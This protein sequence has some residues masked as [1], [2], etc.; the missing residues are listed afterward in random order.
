MGGSKGI[1]EPNPPAMPTVGESMQD[2][3][4]NMPDMYNL[5]KEYA[6]KYAA[7]EFENYQ[8]YMPAYTK[9][10][11]DM[12]RE[13]Y[14]EMFEQRD[15]LSAKATEYMEQGMPDWAREEARDIY[16]ANLGT[17]A[18]SPIGAD[19][20]ST[21]MMQENEKWKQYG[22]NLAGNL[23]GRAPMTSPY[24]FQGKDLTGGYD[25]GNIYQGAQQNYG[26]YSNAYSNMYA[27]NQKQA[28]QVN[29]AWGMAGM[30]GG[31]ML[32]GMFGKGGMFE[33]T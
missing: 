1:A 9:V 32:G 20:M 2:Y 17:N 33:R 15:A 3:I 4:K 24:Q 8:R 18:G 16:S 5:Q 30:L 23:A 13:L 25:F 19:Y 7:D 26:N 12:N 28:G 10:Q 22:D 21:G 6:P 27:T 29:P 14:P 31:G 11:D